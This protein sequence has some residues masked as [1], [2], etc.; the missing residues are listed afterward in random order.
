M[1]AH[2]PQP[3]SNILPHFKRQAGAA[4]SS[5]GQRVRQQRK[6]LEM[7]QRELGLRVGRSHA[8]VSQWERDEDKPDAELMPRVAA[9]LETTPEALLFGVATPSEAAGGVR[10][11]GSIRAGGSVMARSMLAPETVPWLPGM[12]Q[13]PTVAMHVEDTLNVPVYR[14]GDVIYVA[15]HAGLPPYEALD[16][17]VIVELEDGRKLLRHILPGPTL[18]TFNLQAWGGQPLVSVRVRVVWPVLA[19]L[20]GRSHPR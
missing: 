11:T 6:K 9:V 1:L 3:R 16:E 18:E 5:F 4:M 13:R 12:S 2:A 7:S 15:D 20:R 8:A 14:P 10:V 19:V 17:D